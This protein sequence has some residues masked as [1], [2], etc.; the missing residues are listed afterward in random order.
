[1]LKR[2]LN[3]LKVLALI[4]GMLSIKS[5]EG[6]PFKADFVKIQRHS[7]PGLHPGI[8]CPHVFTRLEKDEQVTIVYFGGS[9]TNHPGYRI[10][11]EDG[12]LQI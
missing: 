5:I 11:S 8:G 9:I 2:Q 7:V 10:F 4:L 12:Y 3:Y 6:K 1:M